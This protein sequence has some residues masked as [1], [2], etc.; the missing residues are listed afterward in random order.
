VIVVD[1]VCATCGA[2]IRWAPVSL[3]LCSSCL[4]M[5]TVRLSARMRRLEA[6][7]DLVLL[8]AMKPRRLLAS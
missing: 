6:R 1:A 8:P 2:P 3:R 4:L 5:R 7:Q